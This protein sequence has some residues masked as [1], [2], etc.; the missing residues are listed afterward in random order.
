[1]KFVPAIFEQTE[2]RH[3]YNEK[4]E[5]WWFT[6]VD[7]IQVLTQQPDFQTARNYWR[8]LKHRLQEEGSQVVTDCN[9]LKLKAPDR[10]LTSTDVATAETLPQ[11][12]D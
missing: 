11:F 1:M 8:V 5:T 10:R 3:A 4:T 2:I 6:V 9:R 12:G 7:I